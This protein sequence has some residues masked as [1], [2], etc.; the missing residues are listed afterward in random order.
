MKG[1]CSKWLPSALRW[2]NR[3][4]AR[5]GSVCVLRANLVVFEL[6]DHVKESVC[7]FGLLMQGQLPYDLAPIPLHLS[8]T[9]S[10][11]VT[12]REVRALDLDPVDQLP[13]L[14]RFNQVLFSTVLRQRQ[15]HEFDCTTCYDYVVVP[16]STDLG[17]YEIDWT[18]VRNL[19]LLKDDFR[20]QVEDVR[21]L[22]QHFP[23]QIVVVSNIDQQLYELREFVGPSSTFLSKRKHGKP[24]TNIEFLVDTLGASP[25]DIDQDQPVFTVSPLPTVRNMLMANPPR[26]ESGLPGTPG[27]RCLLPQF[28]ALLPFDATRTFHAQYLPSILMK[29]ETILTADELRTQQLRFSRLPLDLVAQAVTQAGALEP[30][31]NE[32]LETLGD[33]LLELMFT[34]LRHIANLRL[35]ADTISNRNLCSKCESTVHLS[36][37]LHTRPLRLSTWTP[38]GFRST[39]PAAAPSEKI[40][41]DAAEAL[42]A[43]VYQSSDSISEACQCAEDFGIFPCE[44]TEAVIEL[45]PSLQPFVAEEA[46]LVTGRLQHMLGYSFRE[47]GWLVLYSDSTVGQDA[48]WQK[49]LA[50]GRAFADFSIIDHVYEE[51]QDASPEF[52]T[53][54]K[55]MK[56][57]TH[58]YAQISQKLRLYELVRRDPSSERAL[59][60]YL[61]DCRL[62]AMMEPPRIM[63]DAV[64]G[65]AGAVLIDCGLSRFDEALAVLLNLLRPFLSDYLDPEKVH[66]FSDASSFARKCQALGIDKIEYRY[67]GLQ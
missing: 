48:T 65:L 16:I 27:P 31:N 4:Q 5:D 43:A 34:L 7:L 33:S 3:N 52:L 63:S 21:H 67:V 14:A 37:Y 50:V 9:G 20:D 53:D 61:S 58:L 51:Y 11:R 41:A 17:P 56:N 6:D 36:A 32:R 57:V 22:S 49:V 39:Q 26:S 10:A 30:T 38:P 60:D 64:V 25:A 23:G 15:T 12:V 62:F 24:R 2:P 35:G 66:P 19:G 46:T 40:V 59:T 42:L 44:S 8:E 13:C 54:V 45:W 55:R 47:P 28:C 1:T 18:L 29:L